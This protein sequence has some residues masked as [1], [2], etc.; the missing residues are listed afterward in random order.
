[1]LSIKEHVKINQLVEDFFSNEDNTEKCYE[2]AEELIE[3]Y[4]EYNLGYLL[5]LDLLSKTDNNIAIKD[6]LD[7]LINKKTLNLSITYPYELLNGENPDWSKEKELNITSFLRLRA[8]YLRSNIDKTMNKTLFMKELFEIYDALQDGDNLEIITKELILKDYNYIFIR[9]HYLGD[10]KAPH[11][12]KMNQYFKEYYELMNEW[13][14]TVEEKMEVFTKVFS[15]IKYSSASLKISE[16]DDWESHANSYIPKLLQAKNKLEFYEILVEMVHRIGD[17]HNRLSFPDDVTVNFTN[18][19]IRIIYIEGKFYVRS[20]FNY[21]DIQIKAGEEIVSVDGF[22]TNEY[23]EENKNKY[24]LV[25]N[26]HF[27]PKLSA[28]YAMSNDLLTFRKGKTLNVEFKRTDGTK[29]KVEF[30]ENTE[31]KDKNNTQSQSKMASKMLENDILLIDIPAFWGGDVYATFIEN[32]K[33]YDINKIKGIIFDVRRNSGGNSGF[34]DKI[35]S[36]CISEEVKNYFM[37]YTKVHIPI[38]SLD[39]IEDI[40]LFDHV[41]IAPAKELKIDCPVAVLTSPYS[42]SATE[43]FVFLFKY[44][45]RGEII[46]LP[47]AGSTGNPLFS[48]LRG[49]GYLRVNLNI[50]MYY[51]CKGIVPDIYVDNTVTDLLNGSDPQLQKAVSYLTKEN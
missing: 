39:G 45:K 28:L 49:G 36:H 15:E 33:K 50:S 20:D 35:F 6:I 4:I 31:K 48:L 1:M 12:E 51:T 7:Q 25:K 5:K 18:P 47:T 19:N 27:R 23:I 29:Y 43:G 21:N 14:N 8:E 17:N 9:R 40:K 42:G 22:E 11:R 13:S 10:S 37:T 38:H 46:G 16:I 34:G 41:I 30:S 3:K 2:I 44:Y 32:I 26:Y 24:P